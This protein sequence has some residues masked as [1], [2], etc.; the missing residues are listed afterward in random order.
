VLVNADEDPSD[1]SHRPRFRDALIGSFARGLDFEFDV[2]E[3]ERHRVRYS[4]DQFWGPWKL[5]VDNR[6]V[7]RGIRGLSFRTRKSYRFEVG[8][9]ERHEVV[10][11]IRRAWIYAGM[12][13][14]F[15]RVYV[16]GKLVGE[17]VS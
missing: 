4:Y 1:R 3:H 16:D 6:T 13:P 12:K 7:H 2:G 10:I 14:Q 9:L 17:H 8:E 5:E 11:E 15:C